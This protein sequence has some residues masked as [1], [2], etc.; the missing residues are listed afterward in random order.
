[1]K[2]II[3]TVV[4]EASIKDVYNVWTTEEGLN[5]FFGISSKVE[6]KKDGPFEIYFLMDQKPGF[7]GS[8]NCIILDYKP[9]E[10]LLF[11]WNVPPIFEQERSQEYRSI[12]RINFKELDESRTEVELINEY[13]QP[14]DNIEAILKYFDRAWG[15]VLLNL[16]EVMEIE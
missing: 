7:R 10:Y 16:K 9:N 2:I 3:K 11:N 4:I 12:V 8:E 15:M 5:T 6:F 14:S 1:M 13:P